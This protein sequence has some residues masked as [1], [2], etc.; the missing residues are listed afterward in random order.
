MGY[1]FSKDLIKKVLDG[2]KTMTRRP[3]KEGDHV[4]DETC[5][6]V[7]TIKGRLRWAVGQRRAVQPGRGK[8]AVG[9]IEITRLR[10]DGDVRD[11]SAAD[12]RAEGFETP[13]DFIA[14]WVSLYDD[15]VRLEKHDKG[16]WSL[17]ITN[18]GKLTK[19]SHVTVNIK[20]VTVEVTA[21]AAQ[22]IELLK[23][24][25]PEKKYRAWVSEFRRVTEETAVQS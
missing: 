15:K 5:S 6:A 19:G 13:L 14:F 25:R 18:Q 21:K 1:Q 8:N 24:H 17:L 10:Y 7:Y 4:R 23:R 16:R 2:T 12:A 20:Q 3:Y 11:I 9:Y 22:I